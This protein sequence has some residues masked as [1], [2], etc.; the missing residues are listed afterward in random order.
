MVQMNMKME[1]DNSIDALLRSRALHEPATK[2]YTW[3]TDGRRE[4]RSLTYSD[5]DLRARAIAVALQRL[6]VRPRRAA[7]L[8][9]SGL[10]FI[11]ALFACFYAGIPAVPAFAPGAS[12]D[13]PR[14]SGILHD[15]DCGIALTVS[16]SLNEVTEVVAGVS[17]SALCMATDTL[18]IG[19]AAEWR[20]RECEATDIAYLQYTSGS[21]SAPRGVIVTHAG[22]L[23]NLSYIASQGGFTQ[24]S[25]SVNWLPHFHDMGLIY[26]ILQPV[27]SRFPAFLFSPASFM[28]DPL[29][30]LTAISQRRGTH[31][32]GPNFGYDLCVERIA[33]ED[34]HDLDLSSW[35]VA[36]NGAEPVRIETMERFAEHFKPAG[37]QR[38]AFYPVY[39][40]AEACLKVTSG[41]SGAGFH[42][43]EVDA[44]AIRQHRV[45]RVDS[46][47][48]GAY[49]TVSCGRATGRHEV[50]IVDPETLIPCSGDRVG[51]IWV[52]GP[53]VAAG[54]W[55]KADETG[56]IFRAFL[57]SGQGPYLRTGDLGFLVEGELFVTGRLK[58]CIIVRG[59]NH[60]PQDIEQTVEACHSDI[61]PGGSAAFSVERSGREAVV[62]IA[63]LKRRH[64]D[65]LPNIVESI[66]RAVSEKH[67]I[68]A[69][70]IVLVRAG[71]LPKTSSG[72]IQ[73]SACRN[74]FLGNSLSILTRSGLEFSPTEFC[75]VPLDRE[76]VLNEAADTRKEMVEVYL[77]NA[78]GLALGHSPDA[79]QRGHRLAS[80]GMDSLMLF[81]LKQKL[82][83]DLM[84]TIPTGELWDQTIGD[85]SGFVLKQLESS[86]EEAS[87]HRA[88]LPA[89]RPARIPLSPGQEQIWFMQQLLPGSCAYNELF[90]AELT[91]ALDQRHLQG[92]IRELVARHEILRATFASVDGRPIQNIQSSVSVEVPTVDVDEAGD[93]DRQIELFCQSE[94]RR[95]FDLEKELPVRFALLKSGECRTF[96]SLVIHHIAFDGASLRILVR[97]LGTLYLN[98]I[99]DRQVSLPEIRIH[100][101]DYAIQQREWL[102]Q[103]HQPELEYWKRKLRNMPVLDIPTDYPRP[104]IMSD[105]GAR[106]AF[107]LPPELAAEIGSMGRRESM[108]LFMVLLAAFQVVLAK[109]AGQEEVA[110][111]TPIV[112][113]SVP[114]TENLIGMFVNTLALR[115][116]VHADTK[117]C[118]LLKDVRQTT[119]DAYNYPNLPFSMIA[120]ELLLDRDLSRTPLFQ[121]MLV[122]QSLSLQDDEFGPVQFRCLD[123]SAP[124][125]KFDLLLRVIDG[126]PGVRGYLEY[127]QSLFHPDT[128]RQLVKHWEVVLKRM[129]EGPEA[130]I[131]EMVLLTEEEQEQVL[132]EWNRT[133][134]EYEGTSLVEL[135]E[136]QVK[137]TPGAVAVEGRGGQRSYEELNRRTNQLG[138]Y[139][140][141]QGVGPEVRVGICMER[142][143]EMVEG[144]LGILKAGGAYVPLDPG[145]PEDRLRWMAGDAGVLL[146]VSGKKQREKWEGSGLRTMV[147]EEERGQID[148]ERED[149]TGV[150]LERENLAYVIY[151][152]GSTGRPK[153]VAI[154]H[155][156]AVVLMNWARGVFT[157]ED[158]DGMA[159][160]TSICF[161]LSVFEIFAPLSWGGRVVVVED[162]LELA[163]M[164][165]GGR[166]KMINTVPSA[167]R[168]LVR[169]RAVPGSVK[170]INLAGEALPEKLVREIYESTNAERVFNL[171]GPTEDTVYSTYELMERAGGRPGVRIGKPV[172]NT[173]AYVLD[174]GM[175][176]VPVGV[177]GELYLGGRG[178]GRGY[179]QRPDLTAERF[180]PNPYGG[181]GE[182]LYRTGDQVRWDRSGRL[183]YLGRMDHQVKLRGYR[184][185]LGEIES[186]ILEH[187][188]TEQ[189]VVVARGEGEEQKLVAYVVPKKDG[190]RIQGAELREHLRGKLPEYM[191]PGVYVMLEE[192][193]LSANRKIDRKNLPEPEGRTERASVRE[194]V[195]PA[196]G[197]EE[198]LCEI[199]AEIT[200]R[201]RV[202][203]EDSFFELGGHS[204]LAAQ[205]MSRVRRVLGVDLPLRALF[206]SP[207]AR[208]LGKRVKAARGLNSGKEERIKRV[209]R[210]GTLPLSYAQQRLWFLD[211]L[212]SG[213]AAYN[214]PFGL[215]LKGKLDRESLRR[216]IDDLVY[217][218]EALRTR[219]PKRDGVAV[220]EIAESLC[221]G[222]EE[223]DLR[224]WPKEDRDAEVERHAADEAQRRFDLEH[225]PLVRIKL[226]QI[227][228][229]EHLLL[230][231]MHHIISDGW[232]IGVM[233]REISRSYTGYL[234]HEDPKPA[235]LKLQYADFSVW[236]RHRLTGEILE[237]HMA[238]WRKQLAQFATLD[239]PT[240]FPRPAKPSH[241]GGRV[242]FRIGT[243]V[244]EDLRKLA[245][246]E[247]VTLFMVLLGAL[248]ILLARYSG[249]WDVAIGTPVANRNREEMEGVIGFFGNTVVMRTQLEREESVRE[250]LQRVRQMTLEAYDHQELPFEKLVEELAPRRDLSRTPF[251]QVMLAQQNIDFAELRLEGLIATPFFYGADIAKFDLLLLFGEQEGVIAGEVSYLQELW[252]AGTMRQLVKH[253][254]VVLK[255]MVEG[256]EARI[257][258]M[259]L[260]TEEEQEQVLREW[261]RTEGEYEGTSLVE[262]FEA[263]V[264]KTPGAVAVEGRGGQR[265]Y[266]ELNRRTNQLGHYLRKQGVGPEVR[267]GICMERGT[268]MVEGLLGILKAGGAYVPLDPGYP[269]DRLRWMAGDAGVLLVVSGKKQREKWEGSGLRTMVPEEERGQIDGE[270]EDETGVRLERENLAYVIYTSGSTGRPKG[271]AIQH[272]SAVVLMNWARGVFT[273]EDLDGMAASTSICFDLSVF[274]IF[275]PLS[276]GGRVVVVEDALEL[277]RMGEGGR[278]KMINTVPSAMRELVRMRAVPGSVKSINLAGEALPEKLVREIYESTN[279]ERVFNLYGPT[280]DTVYSTY[281]LMERA[282]GR[283]GVRIGKPV[284]NTQAYVLDEG[285]RAVPVG[286]KGELY[287]GGRGLGRGY[288]QRPDLTAERFVPNPYGGEGERLYR[289]GDQ[290]RWDRS[291][292]L[293]YLG[294]MDHQVKLRGYRIELGEIES[295]IL[296]HGGTEQAVVVA[297]GEGEE[298]KLVAYV[299]P[300]KDGRRIQGAELREH[301]RGK[302]PEYMVPGV[303]V[304]LEEMPLSANRKID[305]KNLPEPEAGLRMTSDYAPPQTPIQEILARIWAELLKVNHVGMHENF[306]DLGGHSLLAMQLISRIRQAFGVEL[307]VRLLFE[308]PTIEHMADFIGN[309]ALSGNEI[310]EPVP[311]P[312]DAGYM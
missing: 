147:P 221:L 205:V 270:R 58:D 219:F 179:L 87:G 131:G 15:A 144:L 174:E 235:E 67:E 10:E 223:A 27:F 191:V 200:K 234:R 120:A 60:Y 291:G 199:F 187:G 57:E 298:Q 2:V 295:G 311:I 257:G 209:R 123:V 98:R 309:S 186:G 172:M 99:S 47:A 72:K 33:K 203:A 260:L 299:V 9:P 227:E 62:V 202:G 150:R 155:E 167:M 40:L 133:E 76:M 215:R 22:L 267:V 64:G 210:E 127:N 164:G 177:K 119:V 148:G 55:N 294:R 292:R 284:M 201:D 86:P 229:E 7:L 69:T 56:R 283:P 263:Q 228:D 115:T 277:A 38:N 111:G 44:E 236:Q 304:M 23:E 143:T 81:H 154:Q 13:H 274:E 243:Q 303:Y 41:E 117:I 241:R 239:L 190:R 158:L 121:A 171:Y 195:S 80:L 245:C 105:Q 18:E 65:Q 247:G 211:Q 3:L 278:V 39:G 244:R 305:R 261:N 238:F 185:E 178:L 175:R 256:P 213:V 16:G 183:E 116:G 251:F 288:L 166:V 6:N 93:V 220:Q 214:L 100:Y 17:P 109:Y 301:L 156:S 130:R 5:L 61:K 126:P 92:A 37:F 70:E 138:H 71:S 141:K 272:E 159:A 63:E 124:V 208:E 246:G 135:F 48:P 233:L 42:V 252:E 103:G 312:R 136:A 145:Y 226:L 240:D 8:Y 265:S 134:G 286:V 297:R 129:V 53:S 14:I 293:E 242:P 162:A 54:Y 95:S 269:E 140:R 94:A 102:M 128:M 173:Q 59:Q 125:A 161:D 197:P 255:R 189:A 28:R 192:M 163:R 24:E 114:G 51:E 285:M 52:S 137:K 74:K 4:G 249:Q 259:V 83:D 225:L 84:I 231:T 11:E 222:I 107:A 132:R 237:T 79:V 26:G 97:D 287:L 29:R 204:L 45:R 290:V 306:F 153:G 101:A 216:S 118:D 254:E 142:G 282:G 157:A 106:V 1:R 281:E 122:M 96:L 250:T 218:Q 181:E 43:C 207:T 212:E 264:K 110:V 170:S 206:E 198:V 169:M 262:L 12:R 112:N 19:Q 266:E 108:S 46:G 217:R 88:L 224:S 232:S 35:R 139:L 289:T 248:Q 271:V 21:T 280:E 68:Q 279:A 73:R 34:C 176:A 146:V 194:H 276:W 300:K 296:E 149:E 182:R 113:R 230:V 91:G 188:G 258:E 77:R 89:A 50:L 82:E 302:L 180:V 90:V 275:A 310:P 160:S 168:E 193:P 253:W 30:W 20:E 165:E 31:C 66:R 75:H 268:E 151:T 36:F 307:P 85:L 152:S 184:I 49:R 308:R 104:S 25:V 32:G 273:A 78:V 196:D